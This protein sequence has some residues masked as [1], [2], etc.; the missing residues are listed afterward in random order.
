M[1]VAATVNDVVP[2]LAAPSAQIVALLGED[3]ITGI[4][5]VL[6]AAILVEPDVGGRI[7]KVAAALLAVNNL[8]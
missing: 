1:P 6:Q 5:A 7:A 4:D 2:V 8:A 3:V